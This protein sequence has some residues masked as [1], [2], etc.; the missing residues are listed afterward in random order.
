MWTHQSL[1][2]LIIGIRIVVTKQI[3]L[4]LQLG[5]EQP[6]D[7]SLL[8]SKHTLHCHSETR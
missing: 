7:G 6:G 4:N 8:Y 5:S 3:C 2:A 1:K